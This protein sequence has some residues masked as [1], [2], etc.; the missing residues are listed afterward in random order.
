MN[1]LTD[2]TVTIYCSAPNSA[3]KQ[4]EN[5]II[6]G[7]DHC[8]LHNP[9]AVK[10][11]LS[12]KKI[13]NQLDNIDHNSMVNC[14]TSTNIYKLFQ[15]YALL[16][17]AYVKR[18]K[19]RTYAYVEEQHD[20]GHNYQLKK[21][22][23]L[24]DDVENVL[25]DIFRCEK[26]TDIESVSIKQKVTH[27]TEINEKS[28]LMESASIKQKIDNFKTKRIKLL[29]DNDNALTYYENEVIKYFVTNRNDKIFIE[30]KIFQLVDKLT[31]NAENIKKKDDMFLGILTLSITSI[32]IHLN[33]LNGFDINESHKGKKSSLFKPY[34]IDDKILTRYSNYFSLEQLKMVYKNLL[35]H[36]NI[37]ELLYLDL[38][39]H[40]VN[41]GT[42]NAL[43][44][45]YRIRWIDNVRGTP[46]RF[47]LIYFKI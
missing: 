36:W 34:F 15:Y 32:I 45:R 38:L 37:I 16:H 33:Q 28:S 14:K 3:G 41:N 20:E 25:G 21:L 26:V 23:D 44:W 1:Y 7:S 10:L 43:K 42:M 29:E 13:C 31:P 12:Y 18:L 35:F 47:R 5:Y 17:D 40:A 30:D 39:N 4:C 8:Y 19:H 9:V 6:P 22:Q 11:Y 24:I 2:N 27:V 46:D